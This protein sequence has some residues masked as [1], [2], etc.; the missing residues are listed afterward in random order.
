[1]SIQ[2]ETMTVIAIDELSR[3]ELEAIV[4]SVFEREDLVLCR[5]NISRQIVGCRK[6]DLELTPKH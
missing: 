1:M 2:N 5:K 3:E 6:G 4:R